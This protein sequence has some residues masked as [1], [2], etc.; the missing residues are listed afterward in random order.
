T[1]GTLGEPMSIGNTQLVEYGIFN[2][3]SLLRAHVCVASRVV[4]VF[5]T[6]KV[7]E[8]IRSG[9][10]RNVPVYTGDI[11]TATG[12]L[13]PPMDIPGCFEVHVP[14][15]WWGKVGFR[16]DENTT[17]KGNKAVA[18][19]KGLLKNG[20]FPLK[21]NPKE[22]KGQELQIK[23]LDIYVHLKTLIQVKC[24]YNGGENGTGNLFIQDKECNPYRMV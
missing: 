7:V 5:E 21:V 22:I 10:Y 2:E 24:D 13:V 18:V 3:G 6:G 16:E 14:V 19:V 11:V 4:Y 8:L 23:G 17:I 12:Y 1:G 15:K 9:N 20:L